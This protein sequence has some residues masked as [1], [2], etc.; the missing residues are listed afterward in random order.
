MVPLEDLLVRRHQALC[1]DCTASRGR[2]SG[3]DANLRKEF[4]GRDVLLRVGLTRPFEAAG[5]ETAC[6][7]QV[8]GVYPIG[9]QRRHFA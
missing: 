3:F 2:I 4:W 6:W 9:K 8:T 1:A 5:Q 7:L